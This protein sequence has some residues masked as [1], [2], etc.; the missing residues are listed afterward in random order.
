MKTIHCVHGSDTRIVSWGNFPD[1]LAIAAIELPAIIRAEL[2]SK[3]WLRLEYKRDRD[4]AFTAS[5]PR[6]R[7]ATV[8]AICGGEK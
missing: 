2:F 6:S 4:G 3:S 1:R 8:V 7:L 5:F